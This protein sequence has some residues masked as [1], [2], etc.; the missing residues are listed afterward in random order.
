MLL[1][2]GH[3]P[4]T[5]SAASGLTPLHAAARNGHAKV[6]QLLLRVPGIDV[7]APG[8]GGWTPLMSAASSGN[9]DLLKALRSQAGIEVGAHAQRATTRAQPLAA[10]G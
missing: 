6:V 3:S 10:V 5:R 2:L 9:A 8:A 4:N 7:N 1:D